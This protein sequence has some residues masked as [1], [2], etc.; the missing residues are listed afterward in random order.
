MTYC[1]SSTSLRDTK[2]REIVSLYVLSDESD[3]SL[4]L[5]WRYCRLSS[6]HSLGF[7]FGLLALYPDCQER[8]F[9][10]VQSFVAKGSLPVC[11]PRRRECSSF[12]DHYL[13]DI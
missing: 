12:P 9:N 7:T 3:Y 8:V 13:I 5:S 10:E 6:A 11:R 2:Q 1:S 4:A